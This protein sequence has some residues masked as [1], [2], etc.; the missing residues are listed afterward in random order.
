MAYGTDVTVFVEDTA[1][2]LGAVPSTAPW[3]LSPDVDI[4]AHPG[5]AVQGV[6]DVR[7]R[8]HAH[9]EPI[10]EEKIV[11]EVYVGQ[12]ALVMSP[13][14]GTRRIDPGT[15]RF[16]PA[17]VSGTE[18]I[19]NT[20]GG[21]LSFPWTPS[22]TA[23][24]V[25]G[26]GHRCMIVRAFPESVTPPTSPFDVPNEQ[27]E[28]QRNIEILSTRRDAGSMEE[29]GSGTAESPRRRDEVTGIWWEALLTRA[30]GRRKGRRFIVWAFDPEPPKPIVDGLRKS[31]KQAGVRRLSTDPPKLVTLEAAD[32]PGEE[33]DPQKLLGNRRFAGASGLGKGVFGRG[34]LVAAAAVELGPKKS[35]RILVRFDH[36]NLKEGTAV[37]LHGAQWDEKGRPEG[38]MTIIAVAPTR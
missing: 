21:T 18:P 8:V 25:D 3:W 38:G 34:R 15:L 22:S 4:P 27:H 13:T 17:N 2:D 16:R 30:I 7:I 1:G 5:E 14:T 23:A 36:S 20:A 9:E 37:V 24:D 29:G 6:N 32:A 12:P 31:L 19:A 11:A 33:I 35:S 28:A 10:L 26:P